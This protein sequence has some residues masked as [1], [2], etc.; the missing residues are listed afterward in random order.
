MAAFIEKVGRF[1]SGFTGW[2]MV[3]M[4]MLLVIDLVA[5]SLG[6]PLQ[7]MAEL[8]VFVMMIVIYLGFA[9]CEHE[10][11]HVGLEIVT[12]L[13]S[14]TNRRRIAYLAQG[15]AVITVALLLYAI[16]ADAK[17]AFDTNSAIEGVVDLPLWPTKFIMVVGMVAFLAQAIV[18]LFRMSDV[19]DQPDDPPTAD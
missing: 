5:R 4:M 10:R 9:R 14:W 17:Y 15:L 6:Y 7:L 8:S 11:E 16:I 19:A 1:L 2:L 18:N 13:L 3:A 12:N